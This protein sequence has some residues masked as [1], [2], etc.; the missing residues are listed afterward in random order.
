LILAD[1][2]REHLQLNI[3]SEKVPTLFPTVL[4]NACLITRHAKV[5]NRHGVDEA[6]VRSSLVRGPLQSVRNASSGLRRAA[7]RAGSQHATMR[8]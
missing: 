6:L 8:R 5:R 1:N 3:D 7:R 2:E 4:T